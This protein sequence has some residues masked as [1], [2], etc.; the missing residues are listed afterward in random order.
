MKILQ[1]LPIFPPSPLNFG[2]GVTNVAYHISKELVRRGHKVTVYTSATLDKR[3]RIEN[4][5]NPFIVDGIEVHYFPYVAH[6]NTS[7]I[8]LTIIPYMRKNIKNFDVI[9]LHDY[10]CFQSIIAHHY[11][12][13]YNIPYVLQAHGAVLPIFQKQRLKKIFDLFFGYRLLRDAS[14]VI[15]LTKT[16]TE[17]YK[18][19]GVSEDK[20]EIV[21]NGIDLSEYKTLPEKG[22][23]RKKYFISDKE[24]IILYVGRLHKN[25]GLDLLM[26]IFSDA[27]KKLNGIRL[28]LVGPD[29]GYQSALKKQIHALQMNDRVLFTGFVSNE[30][31]KAAFVD[32][33]VFITPSYSG[34]PITFL[35]ACA[36]GTPIIIT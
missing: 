15:A 25:K 6:Y 29:D 3:R 5:N 31:K 7:F 22:E 26:D 24:K 1:I 28:V 36:C 14:K 8:T 30:G 19:M 34:F 32:A 10:R 9:H 23:F 21:L 12:R 20:I 33:D 18:K 27:L 2:S 17:Q 11:A 35:E 4:I 16:E 13:K